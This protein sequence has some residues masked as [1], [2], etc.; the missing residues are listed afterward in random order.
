[1]AATFTVTNCTV[2]GNMKHVTGTFTTAVGDYSV[3]LAATVHGLNFIEDHKI[4]LDTGGLNTLPPK[5]S[6]SSGTIT[7]TFDDTKGYSGR[8]YVSGR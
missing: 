8:F 2:K 3:D 1:M 4:S 7:M 5:T 6:V